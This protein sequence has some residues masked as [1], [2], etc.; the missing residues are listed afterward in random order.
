MPPTPRK[1]AAEKRAAAERAKAGP[2]PTRNQRA[3]QLAAGVAAAR[4]GGAAPSVQPPKPEPVEAADGTMVVFSF[5]RWLAD[6]GLGGPKPVEAGGRIWQFR[7]SGSTDENGRLFAAMATGDYKSA[8]GLMLV[9]PEQ[10]DELLA[11]LTV[12]FA[13]RDESLMWRQ[14]TEAVSGVTLGESSAS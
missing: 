14:F 8:L 5:D 6:H 10:L 7:A 3:E 9:D 2:T 13:T 11:C 4:N 12:P 1:T